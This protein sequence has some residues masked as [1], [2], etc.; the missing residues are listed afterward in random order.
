LVLLPLVTG[1][2]DCR[3]PSLTMIVP[4]SVIRGNIPRGQI[5]KSA[6]LVLDHFVGAREG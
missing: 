4:T 6:C 2:I 1:D 5:L 3:A